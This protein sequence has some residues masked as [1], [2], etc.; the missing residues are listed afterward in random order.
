M[1]LP[2]KEIVPAHRTDG[3]GDT[4]IFTQY[5]SFSTPEWSKSAGYGLTVNW[6]AVQGGAGATGNPGMVSATKNTPYSVAYIGISFKNATDSARAL[7]RRR[8]RTGTASSFCPT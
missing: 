4:F 1:S 5:L 2:H 7:A 6:P 8:Y 3:S